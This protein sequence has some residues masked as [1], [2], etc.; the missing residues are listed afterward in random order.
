MRDFKRNRPA[1]TALGLS[2]PVKDGEGRGEGREKSLEERRMVRE[3]LPR[4]INVE[5]ATR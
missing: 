1:E 5:I 4:N 2:G 3:E